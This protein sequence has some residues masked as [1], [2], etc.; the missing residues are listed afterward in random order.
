MSFVTRIMTHFIANVL[1]L[2]AAV[3]WI[4]GVAVSGSWNAYV[5]IALVLTVLNMTIKPIL[6]LI[7]SPFIFLTLGIGIIVVNAIVLY[8]LDGIM[9]DLTIT[10]LYPLVYATLL[11]SAV[12]AVI[13]FIAHRQSKTA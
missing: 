2:V 10:G 13:S 8:A 1:A 9:S 7:L 5:K 4:P 11:F 12:N 3:Y 6:K